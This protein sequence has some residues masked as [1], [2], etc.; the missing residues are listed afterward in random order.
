MPTYDFITVDVFTENQFGGNPL[1]VV[2]NADGLSDPQMQAI[3][4]EFNLSETTF[5]LPPEDPA[6]TARMRIFMPKGE[7]PFAGHPNIGTAYALA[8]AGTV[9][10]KPVDPQRLVIEQKAGP[11]P[12]DLETDGALVRGA[13]LTAPRRF[14]TGRTHAVD[15]I[16]RACGLSPDDL[17]LSNHP[18]IV[19]SCGAPFVIVEGRSLDTLARAVP[20]I[21]ASAEEMTD[22]GC[23]GILLYVRTPDGESDIRAR[24]FAPLDGINEDPAT[25]SAN[26][27]LAG[28]L[29]HLD[30]R[31]SL[32]LSLT[33]HQGVEMGRPSRLLTTATKRDGVVET[34]KVAGRCVPVMAGTLTLRHD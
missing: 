32:D 29:A 16:A 1:A 22:P 20:D 18:P 7:M 31:T 14:A 6:N 10:G 27:A 25:G 24:L 30:P 23:T 33:V 8:R 3:A 15:G 13:R 28:L 11:V 12:L 19:G 26:V 17:D 2:L 9:Y 21:A 34:T 4:A 5:V